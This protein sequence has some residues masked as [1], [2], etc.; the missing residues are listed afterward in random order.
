MASADHVHWE[1]LGYPPCPS[2]DQSH[3]TLDAGRGLFIATVKHRGPY[4]RSWYLTTSED[5]RNWSAQELVFHAD[6]VDQENGRSRLRRFFEDPAYLTPVY[7]RPE[8]WRTDVYNFPVFPY[9]GLYLGLPVLQHWSGKHAPL[10]E[11]VDSRKSVE[12]TSSRDL[13]HWER[14][15]NRAPFLELSGVEKNGGAYDTGQIVTSNGPVVRGGQ[16]VVLLLGDQGRAAP[17][18]RRSRTAPAS[19]RGPSAWRGCA[20]TASCPSRAGRSRARC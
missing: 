19:T 2:A 6:Q 10:Y 4:G 13:R 12:L 11:N 18:R 17:P 7:N 9:E 16:A 14:V 1:E 5:F 8:E 3:F 15:A 20:W